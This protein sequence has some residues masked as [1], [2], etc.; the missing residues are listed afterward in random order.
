[1]DRRIK[2]TKKTIKDTFISLLSEKDIKKITVSE[3][4]KLA[5]I[6]RATFNSYYLDVNDLLDKIQE[7]Y[8]Q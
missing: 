5:D 7:E 3:I 4:C 6:N 1:M 2:Y 8:N